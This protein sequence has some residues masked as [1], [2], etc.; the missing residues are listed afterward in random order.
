MVLHA[1]VLFGTMQPA[2]SVTLD[3]EV[4]RAE[5][6]IAA[7]SKVSGVQ[8]RVLEPVASEILFVKVKDL[9]LDAVM[10]SIAR[11]TA[12]SWEKKEDGSYELSRQPSRIA[13]ENEKEVLRRL[14][15]LNKWRAKLLK[16]L[17]LRYEPVAL[18]NAM[19][20][21]H[22]LVT[23]GRHEDLKP[24]DPIHRALARCLQGMDLKP[25]AAADPQTCLVYTF[26]PNA[27]QR[28]LPSGAG[29][30]IERLQPEQ[31]IWDRSLRLM[32]LHEGE[33]GD[34][35]NRFEDGY[36]G[37]SWRRRAHHEA[38]VSAVLE[39]SCQFE[40]TYYVHL[41]LLAPNGEAVADL[42]N[43]DVSTF[44]GPPADKWNELERVPLEPS[45]ET[46][47]YI[48]RS[49]S[50]GARAKTLN[51]VLRPFIDDPVNND[52]LWLGNQELLSALAE[53]HGKSLIAC[54]PD[55]A[56][57]YITDEIDAAGYIER[58]ELTPTETDN[59]LELRPR[60]FA[61]HW[62][63]RSDR[64]AMAAFALKFREAGSCDVFDY[65]RLLAGMKGYRGYGIGTSFPLLVNPEWLPDYAYFAL[66]YQRAYRE[67]L[68]G[69]SPEQL[70]RLKKGET[71]PYRE[72]TPLQRSLSSRAIFGV[73]RD[74]SEGQAPNILA[75]LSTTFELPNGLPA[76]GGLRVS[77]GEDDI[78][79]LH[80]GLD[81]EED[82][83]YRCNL[84]E[85]QR[86]EDSGGI[87]WN[88]PPP[89]LP[90]GGMV[91]STVTLHKQ[92]RIDLKFDL[93]P[94]HSVF[95]R[96]TEPVGKATGPRMSIGKL[97]ATLR[98]QLSPIFKSLDRIGQVGR[99]GSPPPRSSHDR[100]RRQATHS[101]SRVSACAIVR[102]HYPGG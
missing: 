51:G 44:D 79:C 19:G 6:A 67:I 46:A 15:L 22:K 56:G 72:L 66:P 18:A 42:E 31:A 70:A 4:G 65:S 24:I 38:P 73:Q 78:A 34:G 21:R 61:R 88:G 41:K 81:G 59:L 16:G 40:D 86:N 30:A 47:A 9:P 91:N 76:V 82:E 101:T 13:Q 100:N 89:R 69:L 68:L 11:S 98:K 102:H 37:D 12:S 55:E 54:L 26:R 29:A 84:S 52:P 49:G 36:S 35:N 33:D 28:A 45:K 39:L 94:G 14:A 77:F 83:F 5:K 1:L 90:P 96:F 87:D 62:L 23:E 17:E 92:K 97:S 32:P 8:M 85:R 7:L 20:E 53:R 99:D 71:I 74:E 63:N 75:E 10:T 2:A 60:N 50:T 95:G 80:N 57:L 64:R 3:F 93:T 25:L 27:M 43:H 48:A 58:N